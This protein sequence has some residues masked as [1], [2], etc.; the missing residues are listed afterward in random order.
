MASMGLTDVPKN[1]LALQ[2]SGGRVQQAIE[3][4]TTDSIPD[5][6]VDTKSLASYVKHKEHV[7]SNDGERK[8]LNELRSMGF[9]DDDLNRKALKIS[10]YDTEKAVEWLINK[11]GDAD[12]KELFKAAKE[13]QKGSSAIPFGSNKSKTSPTSSSSYGGKQNLSSSYGKSPSSSYGKSPSSKNEFGSSGN[14]NS[15]SNNSTST[16]NVKTVNL[17]DTAFTI[18]STSYTPLPSTYQQQQDL[19]SSFESRM[20]IK[21]YSNSNSNLNSNSPYSTQESYLSKHMPPKETTSHVN[22]RTVNPFQSVGPVDIVAAARSKPINE[23][24]FLSID[25]LK[26]MGMLEGGGSSGGS[27]GYASNSNAGWA[28]GAL[29]NQKQQHQADNDDEDPFA[30]PFAD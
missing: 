15:S 8:Q 5:Q 22:T 17:I 7:P 28:Q 10:L 18:P 6:G 20:Q 9:T 16:K 21:D 14:Y 30:D 3:W 11:T 24:Q 2:R 29:R 25:D 23:Q 19:S 4:V 1:R 12:V 27:A 13:P 26:R